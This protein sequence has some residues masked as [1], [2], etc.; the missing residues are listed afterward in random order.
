MLSTC[1]RA[2]ESYT[3]THVPGAHLRITTLR[4]VSG[5]GIELL[6]YLAPRDGRS[7][8]VDERAN[9]LVHWQTT[10]V[11]D[12][13]EGVRVLRALGSPFV[14]SGVVQL[15][16]RGPGYGRAVLARDPDGHVLQLA[17]E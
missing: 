11:A 5:P 4:A 17:A 8:P 15:S 6:D 3:R 14:S 12:P 10:V 13:T 9:D 16:D 7:F 1:R 2:P